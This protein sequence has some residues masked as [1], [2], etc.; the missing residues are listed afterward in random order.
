MASPDGKLHK[1]PC[2]CMCR[3]CPDRF[4]SSPQGAL[5]C[6]KQI[7]VAVKRLSCSRVRAWTK[8]PPCHGQS[9]LCAPSQAPKLLLPPAVPDGGGHLCPPCCFPNRPFHLPRHPKIPQA[10]LSHAFGSDPAYPPSG[11]S[12]TNHVP[13]SRR[14]G[15]WWWLGTRASPVP[16]QPSV[17]SSW[18]HPEASGA[19]LR[20][21]EFGRSRV[22]QAAWD[23]MGPR[24]TAWERGPGTRCR[25]GPGKAMP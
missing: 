16:F 6:E 10:G 2:S 9:A 19:L 1:L 14:E 7:P 8:P 5:L 23:H 12:G 20:V 22:W 3:S 21:A 18:L 13:R 4:V 11:L 17:S 24:G 25:W 15:R